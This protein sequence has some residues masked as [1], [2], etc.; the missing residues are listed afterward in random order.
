MK[1]IV[2]A[3]DNVTIKDLDYRSKYIRE[4]FDDL[5]RRFRELRDDFQALKGK[6]DS[7]L[8]FQDTKKMR[9]EMYAL[10]ERMEVKE[11]K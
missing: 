5:R 3:D 4:E 2:K 8:S 9:D 6:V 11:K 10:R 1:P 7:N